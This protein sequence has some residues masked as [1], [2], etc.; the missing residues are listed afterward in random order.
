[1]PSPGRTAAGPCSRPST[2]P[3][4][5]CSRW[6]TAAGGTATTTSSRTC[7]AR[8]F[9]RSARSTPAEHPRDR[10]RG[11]SRW[12]EENGNRSEAI[13]H[14]LAA[15]DFEWAATLVEL[16]IPALSQARQ[17]VTLRRWLEALPEEIF[18][19]RPV[20]TIGYVG[21]LMVRGELEGVEERLVDVERWL[22]PTTGGANRDA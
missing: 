19:R 6:T 11:G 7:S 22:D 10:P 12:H 1:M 18:R 21:S 3:T 15:E 13:E 17:E 14:A 16:A 5:S 9:T 8:G 2:G 4:C 20:L